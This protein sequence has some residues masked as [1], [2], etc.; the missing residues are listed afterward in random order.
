MNLASRR[1][2]L[3]TAGLAAL[4]QPPVTFRT[5]VK[6]VRL[7][8]TVKDANGGLVGASDPRREGVARGD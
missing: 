3:A 7:L 4:A 5:E 1:T 6:L 8:A 2:F